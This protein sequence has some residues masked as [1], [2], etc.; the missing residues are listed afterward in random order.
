MPDEVQNTINNKFGSKKAPAE[1]YNKKF[2]DN[3]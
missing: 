3:V 1:K 2:S